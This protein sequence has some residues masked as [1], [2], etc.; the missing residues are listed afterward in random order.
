MA[1]GLRERKKSETRVRIADAADE[2]FRTRGYDAVT[3]DEVAAAADVSKKTV[4]NYFPTKE[5][6]VFDRADDRES[7]LLAAVHDRPGGVSVLE[8]FRQLSLGQTDLIHR[9]RART[10]PG[11]GG[12]FDLV[13]TNPVLQRKMHEVNARMVQSL[14]AALAEEVAGGDPDDPVPTVVAWTLISAQRTLLRRLRQRAA[15]PA[16]EPAIA[17]AHRRDVNRVF[18]Q[19]ALGLAAYPARP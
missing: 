14:S 7:A 2:L 18:D 12:F 11:N 15:T 4:F 16:S 9:L 3:V 10:G 13:N 5:D 19:L 1:L 8:A 17:R 6:L